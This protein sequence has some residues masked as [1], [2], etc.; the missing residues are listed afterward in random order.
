ND[1]MDETVWRSKS[2]IDGKFT[3]RQ[4]YKDLC[5]NVEI[6]K[7]H[8]VIWFSQNI[9]KH[10]FILWMAVQ[11]RLVTQDKVRK[12]GSFDMM[13]CLLCKKEMDSH[14]HLFFQCDYSA[15][16][17]AKIKEKAG[18]QTTKWEWDEIV[19]EMT[20]M[21][22]GNSIDSIIRRISFA[23]DVYLIWQ[24]RNWRIFR[25]ERRK[26]VGVE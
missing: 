5:D 1:K 8:K 16:V 25:D 2:G 24:E 15:E 9:P 6:V 12:W 21:Y 26:L 18:I 23:A 14:Q 20:T 11:N 10:S 7:W 22:C 19:E 13:A 17:W 4:A 3:I